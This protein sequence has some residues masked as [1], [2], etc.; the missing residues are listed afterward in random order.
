ML[1]DVMNE[2][3]QAFDKTLQQLI[4]LNLGFPLNI[5]VADIKKYI[6]NEKYVLPPM[7]PLESFCSFRLPF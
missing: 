3:Q 6:I 4:F 7:T 5:M 1:E 2:A